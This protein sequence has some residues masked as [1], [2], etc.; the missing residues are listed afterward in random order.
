MVLPAPEGPTSATIC[1]GSAVN[2]TP[3][4]IQSDGSSLNAALGSASS[5]AIDTVDG[6]G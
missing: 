3:L 5:E 4:R 6:A 1:P 2:D